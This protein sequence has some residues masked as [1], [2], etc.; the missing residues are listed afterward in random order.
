M[1]LQGFPQD[2]E[3]RGPLTAWQRLVSEAVSPPVGKAIAES[4]LE[5]LGI[6]L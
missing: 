5:Q 3:F 4:I 1:L 6:R 2:F